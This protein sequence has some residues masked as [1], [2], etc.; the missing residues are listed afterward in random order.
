MDDACRVHVL[1][2]TLRKWEVRTWS[3]RYKDTKDVRGS[4][5]ESTG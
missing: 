4:D 5:R 1:E 2:A 3:A